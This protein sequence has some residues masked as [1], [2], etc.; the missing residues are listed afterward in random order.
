MVKQLGEGVRGSGALQANVDTVIEVSR[1]ASGRGTIKA[2]SKFRIGN[3]SKVKL[4]YPLKSQVIGRDDD[5]DDI[6]V[7][8]AVEDQTGPDLAVDDT[9]DD[10][11]LSDT[12]L[13]QS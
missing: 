10:A 2:G 9:D 12:H 11:T 7:V 3:P 6:D 5:G 13:Q 1:D 8:L 4:G